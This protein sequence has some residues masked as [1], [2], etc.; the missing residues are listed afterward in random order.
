MDQYEAETLKETNQNKSKLIRPRTN[1]RRSARLAGKVSVPQIVNL[2]TIMVATLLNLLVIVNPTPMLC[3][4]NA[5]TYWRVNNIE[6]PCANFSLDNPI[7]TEHTFDLYKP[8]S[9]L[10]DINA[11]HCTIIEE[12]IQYKTDLINNRHSIRWVNALPTT[13]EQCKEMWLDRKCIYGDLK[14][15]SSCLWCEPEEGKT[16]NVPPVEF[17]YFTIGPK[18]ATAINCFITPKKIFARPGTKQLLSSLGDI[19]NCDFEKDYCT[20]DDNSIIIWDSRTLEDDPRLCE[21]TQ[22]AKWK[23]NY[24]G[25]VWISENNQFAISFLKNENAEKGAFLL[26]F[27]T[28]KYE[29]TDCNKRLIISDQ[30]IG[31]PEIQYLLLKH[32]HQHR[33]RREIAEINITNSQKVASSDLTLS[34]NKTLSEMIQ[35]GITHNFQLA[36]QMT[37]L[38]FLDTDALRRAFNHLAGLICSKNKNLITTGYNGLDAT[39]ISRVFLKTPFIKAKWLSKN[40]IEVQKCFPIPIKNISFVTKED[41]YKQIPVKVS[42]KNKNIS[43]FIDSNDL[44]MIENAEKGKCDIYENIILEWENKLIK[45]NQRTGRLEEIKTEQIHDMTLGIG[46]EWEMPKIENHI[47]E[48]FV[49]EN[50]TDPR[51]EMIDMFR[52]YDIEKRFVVK[53]KILTVQQGDW[54]EN[55]HI[56]EDEFKKLFPLFSIKIDF[57][58]VW[59]YA[60]STYVCLLIFER[61]ILPI[62]LKLYLQ[63]YWSA[64]LRPTRENKNLSQK[65]GPGTFNFNVQNIFP[66]KMAPKRHN[67]KSLINGHTIKKDEIT[68]KEISLNSNKEEDEL[69]YNITM[70]GDPG[71]TN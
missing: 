44:T 14:G 27:D 35:D 10:V 1:M 67:P 37:A 55:L 22:F 52:N 56:V 66:T 33:I 18:N 17:S 61:F 16:Q 50:Y 39:A 70:E 2:L 62:L 51:T 25:N 8:N 63:N 31:V 57:E 54:K 47:F 6:I 7:P 49:T 60:C 9:K 48:K 28:G 4:N 5:P 41:C 19:S 32:K 64:F 71:H 68:F 24:M 69:S 53:N 59:I 26:S 43:A 36:A 46:V 30:G 42:I 38:D 21:F 40:I 11:A 20:Q 12:T 13:Y 58:K 3:P 15:N 29:W 23:G 65:N 34:P 45:V